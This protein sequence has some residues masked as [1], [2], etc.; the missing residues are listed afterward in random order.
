MTKRTNAFQKAIHY[1]HDQLKDT[2]VVVIES[3]EILEKNSDPPTKREIDVLIEKTINDKVFRIAIECRDR[4]KIDDI[5]WIDCL[6]GKFINLPIHK[7]IAV[8]KSGFSKSAVKKAKS[9]GIELRTLKEITFVDWKSEYQKLG[10]CELN[11]TFKIDKYEFIIEGNPQ[12]IITREDKIKIKGRNVK[13]KTFISWFIQEDFWTRVHQ[14]FNKNMPTLYRTKSDLEQPALLIE[15]VPFKN[16]K[17]L[18]QNNLYSLNSLKVIIL[19]FPKVTDTILT[20]YAYQDSIISAGS[21]GGN[22]PDEKINLLITQATPD[23]KFQMSFEKKKI[24]NLKDKN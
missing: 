16:V 5:Q 23:D 13:L 1:I 20:R 8:S 10:F 4:G 12:I 17:I 9:F 7:I 22:K 18:H 14:E 6:I 19:G 24:T 3:A 21:M 2:N 11:M 15:E